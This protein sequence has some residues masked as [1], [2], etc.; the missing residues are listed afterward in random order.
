MGL[1]NY[2]SNPRGDQEEKLAVLLLMA[3]VYS[4]N[5]LN[6]SQGTLILAITRKA[7]I[8]CPAICCKMDFI[9]WSLGEHFWAIRFLF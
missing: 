8:P 1:G 9:L 6:M 3:I 2:F 4:A 7:A 5:C